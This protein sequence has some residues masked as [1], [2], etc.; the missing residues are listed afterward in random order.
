[1]ETYKDFIL[2][3]SK[4]DKAE[5][6]VIA[7]IVHFWKESSSTGEVK[8]LTSEMSSSDAN[9]FIKGCKALIAKNIIRR[10]KR[11]HYMLHPKALVPRDRELAMEIWETL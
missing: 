9:K 3:M 8:L 5:Q 1:M 2:E 6:F 7:G 10:T 11:S 4:M